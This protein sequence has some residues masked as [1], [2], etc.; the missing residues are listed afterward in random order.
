[1]KPIVWFF[2]GGYFALLSFPVR[3]SGGPSDTGH[4][5]VEQACLG[6]EEGKPATPKPDFQ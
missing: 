3:K 1:M 6:L 4:L 2:G 5:D